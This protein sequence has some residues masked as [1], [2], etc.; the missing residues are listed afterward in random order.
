[1]T[2]MVPGWVVELVQ[3]DDGRVRSDSDTS[4]ARD[5]A[6]AIGG[7][8]GLGWGLCRSSTVSKGLGTARAADQPPPPPRPGPG[9][10]WLV[11]R[12]GPVWGQS[13][14]SIVSPQRPSVR[15]WRGT[16]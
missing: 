6:G 9:L 16:F 2:A 15:R 4:K 7:G 11:V 12:T 10:K 8:D 5:V 3:G 13:C 1:M 14:S